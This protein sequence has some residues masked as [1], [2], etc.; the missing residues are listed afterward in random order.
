MLHG[1]Q[2]EPYNSKESFQK[3]NDEVAI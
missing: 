1:T 3:G 2:D